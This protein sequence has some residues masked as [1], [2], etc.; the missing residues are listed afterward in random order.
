MIIDS[1]A[2]VSLLREESESARFVPV[3]A[4]AVGSAKMSTANYFEAAIV[5][6]A[7]DSAA[8]SERL[9]AVIEYF[10]I[11]L[12]PVSPHHARIARQTYRRFG[13]G[14]HPA[15]LNFG[16]CFAYAL[17]KATGEP[18]LFKGEDFSKTDIV[19]ASRLEDYQPR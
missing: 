13:K 18:L 4:K 6:D 17:A 7:N 14:Y 5:I 8:L 2:L 11:E 1:S 15:G 10:S 9:D 3:I 12:V 19:P 16:D